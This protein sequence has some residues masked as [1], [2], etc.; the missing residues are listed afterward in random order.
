MARRP[1]APKRLNA[2]N[3]TGLGADRLG[4]LLMQAADADPI[5]KRR[6]RLILAA[7]AGADALALELDKR[8][9]AVAASRAR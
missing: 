7:E 8:L 3:L 1:P 5:L 4:D 6:L 9:T 2:A